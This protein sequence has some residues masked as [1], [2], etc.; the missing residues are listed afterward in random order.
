MI[1]TGPEII[2]YFN[3]STADIAAHVATL[4]YLVKKIFVRLKNWWKRKSFQ[5]NFAITIT[6]CNKKSRRKSHA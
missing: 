4:G 6:N 3:L 2:S 1:T 5:V